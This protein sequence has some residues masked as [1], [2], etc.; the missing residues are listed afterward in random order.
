MTALLLTLALKGL[1]VL[2]V[3]MLAARLLRRAPASA[4]HGVWAAAFGALLLLPV[5][6]A[7][8]PDWTLGV[9]PAEPQ[10]VAFAPHVAVAPMAPLA[11][12]PPMPPM[13]PHPPMPPAAP[14]AP[15][16]AFDGTDARFDAEVAAYEGEVEAEMAAF[17]HEMAS[18]EHEMSAFE[19]EMESVGASAIAFAPRS[20]APSVTLA[21]RRAGFW[22]G[23]VWLLGV[24]VVG[25]GWVA[26]YL[27]ARRI[28]RDARPETD[29]DWGVLAERA[30]RLSG[31][32]GPVR[33]LRTDA[34]DVPIA[35][36][37]GAPAVVLPASAD[38]WE[39]DRREA[40]LLHEM[41]HL[42]RRDAWTQALAQ[43]ALTLHWLNPLAWWGYRHFL[44]EREQACDDAV[45]AGGARP[46]DYAAHLVTVA[47][48]LRREPHAL[49]ALAPMARRGP[50]EGRIVS[51]LDADR[52]R[53]AL[54]RIGGIG[55][56]ALAALVLVPLA[57]IQPVARALE[58]TP[59]VETVAVA[60]IA[61]VGAPA[62]AAFEPAPVRADTDSVRVRYRPDLDGARREVDRARRE[63]DRARADLSRDEIY[64]IRRQALD[65][66]RR[67]LDE[68]DW[69]E[70][71]I[72]QAEGMRAAQRAL[73]EIDWEAIREAQREGLRAAQRALDEVDWDEIHRGQDQALREA[74]R[75]M[76]E[77]DWK[78]IRDAQRQA[79]DAVD[80]P[81]AQREAM[82]EARESIRESMEDLR[83]A[84]KEAREAERERRN[85]ARDAAREAER[86]RRDAPRD[87]SHVKPA[88]RPEPRP[89][90]RAQ[91]GPSTPPTVRMTKRVVPT[92]RAEPPAPPAPPAVHVV[93]ERCPDTV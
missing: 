69:T 92:V 28:V 89:T 20:P 49:A 53:G 39:E 25:L 44:A 75:A 90:L 46:S 74:Q 7:V 34:L 79:F 41:A 40:V 82:E 70:V 87:R 65:D 11:P 51:I 68:V 67:A 29:A 36:G 32:E 6:E 61:P 23:A 10:Q 19:A 50:L 72:A 64:E 21:G 48:G 4:R 78:E 8:G 93:R 59:L 81:E 37:Y 12:M 33:L 86:D 84:Q 45:L 71:E 83:E 66:A 27:A 47:R 77:V 85:D 24:L 3:A 18:F 57:A 60:E 58:A 31:I 62:L 14:P 43:A 9:L 88:P 63:L 80:W 91:V 22:A 1:L 76:E 54:G 17:E 38:D 55:T 30:R 16:L 73:D 56:I 42:R 2:L 13:P 15:A 35:W 52:Q 26:A 5:L